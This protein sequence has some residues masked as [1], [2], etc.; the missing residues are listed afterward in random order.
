M[1]PKPFIGPLI[2]HTKSGKGENL[3]CFMFK[4]LFSQVLRRKQQL[5]ADFHGMMFSGQS[6]FFV[7]HMQESLIPY[8]SARW[9]HCVSHTQ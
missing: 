8:S 4:K 1:T 6:K 9:I 5:R 2:N 3:P 7:Q